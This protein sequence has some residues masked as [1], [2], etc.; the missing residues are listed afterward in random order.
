M[1]KNIVY[2]KLGLFGLINLIILNKQAEYFNISRFAW[3]LLRLFRLQERI[4]QK[5]WQSASITGDDGELLV[6]KIHED[7]TSICHDIGEESLNNSFFRHFDSN[8]CNKIRI[9]LAKKL[10]ERIERRIFL[11]NVLT[12]GDVFCVSD[13]LCLLGIMKYAQNNEIELERHKFALSGLINSIYLIIRFSLLFPLYQLFKTIINKRRFACS[14][15]PVIA[16]YY[17]LVDMHLDKDKRSALF[18]FLKSKL[19][20]KDVLIYFDRA[21]V[22]CTDEMVD[23]MDRSGI[24]YIAINKKAASSNRVPIWSVSRTFFKVLLRRNLSLIFNLFMASFKGDFLR[25]IDICGLFEFNCFYAYNFDFYKSLNIKID[26]IV[27][28]DSQIVP[29]AAALNDLGGVFVQYQLA[30]SPK[31]NITLG[32]V[33]DVYFLFGP[34]YKDILLKSK[35]DINCFAYSGYITDYSFEAVRNKS[36]LLRQKIMEN[37]AKFIISFFDESF[38][39][40]ENEVFPSTRA[41]S[42]YDFFA[43]L[44]ID[45]PDIAVIHK[46]KKAG[47]SFESKLVN[48]A[49][50]TKRYILWTGGKYLTDSFPSEIAQ[51]SD[52]SVS[53]LFGGTVF[54]ETILSNVPSVF[55]DLEKLYYYDEYKINE[56][57][58]VFDNLVDLKKHIFSLKGKV[59]KNEPSAELVEM[60]KQKD[61]FQDGRAIERIGDYLYLLFEGL[62]NGGEKDSVLAFASN[63]YAKKWGEQ[64]IEC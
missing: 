26:N 22:P 30:N 38:G 29:R 35:S 18:L 55:L 25:P 3:L 33:A 1:Q 53:L 40:S 32:S 49:L 39:D 50:K 24:K 56:K 4:N 21:D 46:P 60:L 63:E 9:F 57:Q 42:I 23:E 59:Q 12:A 8:N 43:E 48:Q 64:N 20:L 14:R 10:K 28:W 62:K 7:I 13:N 58:F 36:A 44:V 61:P 54:L 5:R 41:K 34:Y 11:I 27:S 37:G 31:A 17:N 52:L 45:N 16:S 2:E 19:K 6:P 15:L 51:A 47:F